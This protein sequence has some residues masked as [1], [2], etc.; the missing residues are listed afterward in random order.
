MSEK[1]SDP[2]IRESYA[3]STALM[4]TI[5]HQ[6]VLSIVL[7]AAILNGRLSAESEVKEFVSFRNFIDQTTKADPGEYLARSE[8]R[9]KDA[10]AFEEMREHILAMYQGV[11]VN[12][13]FV[14]DSIQVISGVSNIP[15]FRKMVLTRLRILGEI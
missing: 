4:K 10:N 8:S 5:R 2:T 14:L 7:V 1:T 15:S 3:K 12:H 6:I 9:V 13:S 11:E